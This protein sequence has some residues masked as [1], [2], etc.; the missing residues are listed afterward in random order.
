MQYYNLNIYDIENIANYGGSIRCYAQ[1]GTSHFE[2]DELKRL[3]TLETSRKINDLQSFEIFKNRTEQS[4]FDLMTLLY[5][6]KG[7]QKTIVGIG[8]PGRSSTLL[9]YCGIDTSILPYIAEQSTCLK[10]GLFSPGSHIPIIDEE[11]MFQEKPDY[12]LLLTWHYSESII[13]KLRQKG[14]RSKIIL[15]LPDVKIIEP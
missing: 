8:C 14:F 3:E 11:R 7:E 10:L 1:K 12:A 13:K 5:N 2:S 4:K 6:I 9:N 15:P